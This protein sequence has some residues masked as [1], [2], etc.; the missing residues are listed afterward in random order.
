MLI[1]TSLNELY[2]Q[3]LGTYGDLDTQKVD[4]ALLKTFFNRITDYILSFTLKVNT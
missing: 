4:Q 3:S 1:R 2:S